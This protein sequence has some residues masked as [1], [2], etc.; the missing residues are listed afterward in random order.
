MTNTLS[1]DYKTSALII[2]LLLIP[3]VILVCAV[4]LV[5]ACFDRLAC[6]FQLP[7]WLP[8]WARCG[9]RRFRKER[10]T[11]DLESSTANRETES[12]EA[13]LEYATPVLSREQV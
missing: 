7:L 13:N 12:S 3:I 6:P 2:A 9:N 11:S 1:R 4:A 5:L 10:L 8:S